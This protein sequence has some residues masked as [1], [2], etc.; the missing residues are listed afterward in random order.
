MSIVAMRLSCGPS[1]ILILF[2]GCFRS[3][4]GLY[5]EAL[6]PPKLPPEFLGPVLEHYWLV[7][8]VFEEVQMFLLFQLIDYHL[9]VEPPREV[10]LNGQVLLELPE[11]VH[12]LD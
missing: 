8:V 5:G 6:C 1:L 11:L 12:P 10:A 2:T 4:H 7:P 9:L 3:E